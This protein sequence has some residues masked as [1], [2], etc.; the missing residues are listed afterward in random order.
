MRR[1]LLRRGP[2]RRRRRLGDLHDGRNGYDPLEK[3]HEGTVLFPDEE[4]FGRLAVLL[5][6]YTRVR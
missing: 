6:I 5:V 3:A 2:G 4:A 1:Q